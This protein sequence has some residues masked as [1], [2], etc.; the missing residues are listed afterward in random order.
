MKK[1]FLICILITSCTKEVT[2][3]IPVNINDVVVNGLIERDSNAKIL[4]S[5]SV[6]PFNFNGSISD[7]QE[8]LINDAIIILEE[9][10]SNTTETISSLKKTK[11]TPVLPTDTWFYNYEGAT[12]KGKEGYTYKL[13]IIYENDTLISSTTIPKAPNTFFEPEFVFRQ[14][15]STYCYFLATYTDPDTIGNCLSIFTKTINS[16][17]PQQNLFPSDSENNAPFFKR[18][19]DNGGNYTDEYTN[20]LTFTFPI[21]NGAPAW[22]ENWGQ[23][24]WEE[25]EIDG[26]SGPTIGF[27]NVSQ[28]QQVIIKRSYLDINS[29]NFWAS[30]INNNS[31]G[32]FGTPSNV[33]S[34]II[35]GTGIWYGSSSKYDTIFTFPLQ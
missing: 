22:W 30:M 26:Y 17:Y 24:D 33:Q 28:N 32:I 14:T 2:F 27:W 19:L 18:V 16:E 6:N 13:K 31:P 7:L 3:D 25:K 29:W 15:D 8:N 23:Q 20:G 35:G 9:V 11:L 12:I 5:K 4:L 21:N 34:N 1:I 10:N